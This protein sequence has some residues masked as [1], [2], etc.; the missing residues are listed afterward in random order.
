M[1]N[2]NDIFILDGANHNNWHLDVAVEGL[3]DG[4]PKAV[5]YHLNSLLYE[6]FSKINNDTKTPI[7]LLKFSKLRIKDGTKPVIKDIV[8]EA[9]TFAKPKVFN[10]PM[11]PIIREWMDLKK[12]EAV[13]KLD[14]RFFQYLKNSL[15]N[16]R[17]CCL[18]RCNHS[19][20][21]NPLMWAHYAD[22]HKGICIEYEITNDMLSAY[23]NDNQVLKICD[24]RYRAS[25]MMND[26]ITLDNAL[27][28]KGS[29]WEYEHET[30]LLYYDQDD[31]ATVR[32]SGNYKCLSGFRIKS[33]YLG[34]RISDVDKKDVLEACRGK[35]VDLYQVS[36]RHDDITKL[37][38]TRL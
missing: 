5:Y 6:E 32:K 2:L 3:M 8:N 24:V 35:H 14:K 1:R 20:H 29:P 38:A 36:F 33:I 37:T 16:L 10:D 34:Y 4:D 11:D 15:E 30:R 23:N 19:M 27:L 9:L 21:L 18:S 17:V 25:K 26:Y 7:N 31:V 22:M 12:K 13:T 28:A